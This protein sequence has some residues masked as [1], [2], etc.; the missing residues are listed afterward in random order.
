MNA[1]TNTSSLNYYSVFFIALVFV[2][3]VSISD[4]KEDGLRGNKLLVTDL[5]KEGIFDEENGFEGSIRTILEPPTEDAASD[6]SSSDSEDEDAKEDGLSGGLRSLSMVTDLFKE[7]IFNEENGFEGSVRTILAPVL[8]AEDSSDSSSSDSSSDSEDEECYVS[9]QKED[10]DANDHCEYQT[11][12]ITASEADRYA[13]THEL[14][15]DDQCNFD[16]HTGYWYQAECSG[17]TVESMRFNI[18]KAFCSA[19]CESCYEKDDLP[20]IMTIPSGPVFHSWDEP[21]TAVC[22]IPKQTGE[23]EAMFVKFSGNCLAATCQ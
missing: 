7:G 16:L 4:A 13:H 2:A 1:T 22:P 12:D 20:N 15:A 17:D 21:V 10:N 5:F 11:N 14:V 18:V 23:E 3:T 9:F 19:G 8:A 6:S